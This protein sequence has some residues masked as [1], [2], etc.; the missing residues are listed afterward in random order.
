MIVV[1]AAY[2]DDSGTHLSSPVVV[3]GGLLGTEEQWV[4]FKSEWAKLLARPLDGK[5]RLNQF[6]LSR[7]Q[8]RREEFRD[9]TPTERDHVIHLFNKVILDVGLVTIAA[10]VNKIA[11]DQ[12]VVGNVAIELGNPEGLCFVK[13]LEA[14]MS[15]I[16]LRKPGQ[17]VA[18]VFDQGITDRIEGLAQLYFSQSEIYPELA[19]IGFGKVAD[20]LPLQGAD[21][22]ATGSY[23]FAQEW[24]RDR[25]DAVGKAFFQDYLKRELSYGMVMDREHIEEIVARVQETLARSSC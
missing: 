24:L 18:L 19:G 2:F 20:V 9:Y 8:A 17:R 6:H 1:L 11:W 10:A 7:C 21:M 14:V 12:L 5:P 16:R 22:I 25:E 4:V 15:T 23:Q 13:C 3:V